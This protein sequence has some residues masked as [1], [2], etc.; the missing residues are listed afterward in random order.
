MNF[1]L[2]KQSCSRYCREIIKQSQFV[3]WNH[4]RVHIIFLHSQ[5]CYFSENSLTILTKMD[6]NQMIFKLLKNQEKILCIN[7]MSSYQR[8]A[9]QFICSG[10]SIVFTLK[11]LL[12]HDYCIFHFLI[13]NFH[14]ERK[15]LRSKQKIPT[16]HKISPWIEE[17]V[18]T[19]EENKNL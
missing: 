11:I 12:F 6:K 10:K 1:D 14:L 2:I 8:R 16:N 5:L 7:K 19:F 3:C 4:T 15:N 13:G 17:F 18:S 9:K